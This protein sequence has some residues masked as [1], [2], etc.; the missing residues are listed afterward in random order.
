MTTDTTQGSP[1][2]TPPLVLGRLRSDGAPGPREAGSVPGEAGSV[3]GEAG[4]GPGK[5]GS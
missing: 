2:L 5:A 4:S 1:Q 3:T